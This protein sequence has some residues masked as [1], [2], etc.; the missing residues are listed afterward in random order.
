MAGRII[1]GIV[2][3][4]CA[5][6]FYGIGVHA[7]KREKPMW[8]WS[9]VEVPA[10]KI[11]D[12][13]R[14]NCENARMWKC[15]ALI[16]VAAGAAAIWSGLASAIILTLGSTVGMGLLAYSYQRIYRKYSVK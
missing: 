8:F 7:G 6:V 11:T 2:S 16:F 1:C 14:Y 13:P 15:F 4:L 3:L 12:V 9:G 5:A 10:A